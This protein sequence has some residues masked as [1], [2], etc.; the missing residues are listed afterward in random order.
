M[1]SKTIIS[2]SVLAVCC[3]FAFNTFQAYKHLNR[4]NAPSQRQLRAPGIVENRYE[5]EACSIYKSQGEHWLETAKDDLHEA[6]SPVVS[7]LVDERN[8]EPIIVMG[9]WAAKQIADGRQRT[10]FSAPDL[11]ANDVDAYY[12]YI[13]EE[14]SNSK[15]RKKPK[16]DFSIVVKT[17]KYH[18]AVLSDGSEITV[19]TVAVRGFGPENLLRMNDID[20][21]GVAIEARRDAGS[22][23]LILKYHIT[24]VYWRFLLSKPHILRPADESNLSAKVLVRIAYKSYQMGLGYDVS[25]LNPT[26]GYLPNNIVKKIEAMKDWSKNPIKDYDLVHAAASDGVNAYKLVSKKPTDNLES[27]ATRRIQ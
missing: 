10:G 4:N 11:I 6:I 23:E 5:T 24:C 7:K 14:E 20:A 13:E 16:S 17:I 19:N 8:G 18:N 26:D 22:G 25:A 12:E 21:T 9:S 2:V 3:F 27:R 15:K 1:K